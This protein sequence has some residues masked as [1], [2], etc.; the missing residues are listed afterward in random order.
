MNRILSILNL[1]KY[2]TYLTG[3]L[4]A[5]SFIETPIQWLWEYILFITQISIGK[6]HV[7]DERKHILLLLDRFSNNKI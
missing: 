4:S 6:I 3:I 2:V 5:S 7:G 1:F